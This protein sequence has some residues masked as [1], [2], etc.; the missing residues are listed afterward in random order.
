MT[1]RSSEQR[2]RELSRG[3]LVG[4]TLESFVT[5][6]HPLKLKKA[7]H[8][9]FRHARFHHGGEPEYL[10][11]PAAEVLAWLRSVAPCYDLNSAR[12]RAWSDYCESQPYKE[13]VTLSLMPIT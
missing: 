12:Q 8:A 13:H 3:G 4:M 11:A 6:A 5:A 2:V 7:A 1:T 9:K 10:T